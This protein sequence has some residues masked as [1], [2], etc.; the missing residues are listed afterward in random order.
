M[1]TT[2][3]PLSVSGKESVLNRAARVIPG[4]VNSSV[5]NCDPRSIVAV[6]PRGAYFYDIDGKK[7]IDYQAAFGPS[8]LGHSHP[9]VT[10]K[11]KAG[12]EDLDPV[13]VG[14][15]SLEVALA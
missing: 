12:L 11:V 3:E 4:G 8:I 15:S 2:G 9:M 14:V 6:K 1:A 10:E 5:R 7:Y 13:A